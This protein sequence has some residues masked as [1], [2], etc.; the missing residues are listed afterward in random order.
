MAIKC[1]SVTGLTLWPLNVTLLHVQGQR[2]VHAMCKTCCKE[3]CKAEELICAGEF[4][5]LPSQLASLQRRRG[6]GL[7]SFFHVSPCSQS[8]TPI[9][10]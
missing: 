1:Y 6:S 2:C 9:R 3:K 8:C 7:Q 10:L 4:P 5:S